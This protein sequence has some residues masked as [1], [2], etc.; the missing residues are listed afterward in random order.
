MTAQNE[1]LK[2]QLMDL[3]FGH[4]NIHQK[5]HTTNKYKAQLAAQT[6][7]LNEQ[8]QEI[9]KMAMEKDRAEGEIQ[10]LRRQLKENRIDSQ[11]QLGSGKLPLSKDGTEFRK[12]APLGEHS[13]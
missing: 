9:L 4:S 1:T 11:P 10:N 6:D 8:R 12:P 13:L 2:K 5:I 3:E 7:Q